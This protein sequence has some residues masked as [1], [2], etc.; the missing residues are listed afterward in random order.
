[1]P[2]LS[3]YLRLDSFHIAPLS[4]SMKS[5]CQQ[6]KKVVISAVAGAIFLGLAALYY[7]AVHQNSHLPEEQQVVDT[8]KED[9]LPPQ[10]EL[11]DKNNS[12]KGIKS[13]VT[14][15][16]E[17]QKD[18]EYIKLQEELSNLVPALW[19]RCEVCRD[20]FQKNKNYSI[21][22]AVDCYW[23]G[24]FQGY[25]DCMDA[26]NELNDQE[27]IQNIAAI[28]DVYKKAEDATI[29]WHIGQI[30]MG[31]RNGQW[32][33]LGMQYE[34]RK[35][36]HEARDA[37]FVCAKRADTECM[38]G[39]ERIARKIEIPNMDEIRIIYNKAYDDLINQYRS[40]AIEKNSLE[41]WYSLGYEQ[42]QRNNW[43]D[44]YGA[45]FMSRE[46]GRG[47]LDN[48]IDQAIKEGKLTEQDRADIEKEYRALVV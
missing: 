40:T 15:K 35:R 25:P 45:F 19:R 1:M 21:K 42:R 20:F 29:N 2:H 9:K 41:A 17:P 47:R 30:Q 37:F 23:P 46:K 27:E 28:R 48:W 12:P 18:P 31:D 34:D 22:D 14:M 16:P 7:R 33:S 32:M 13:T 36:F 26:I 4:I 5:A 8:R 11:H 3:T 24:A 39:L 44:M 38:K 6:N 10:E 43:R